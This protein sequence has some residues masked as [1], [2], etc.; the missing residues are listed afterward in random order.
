[1]PDLHTP[2]P[3]RVTGP[4]IRANTELG[5]GALVATVQ[6][7]RWQRTGSWHD[8][9]HT[10]GV[11]WTE[12]LAANARLIAA[13][14][15]MLAALRR[16]VCESTTDDYGDGETTIDAAVLLDAEQAIAKAEGEEVE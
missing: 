5:D 13:A 16:V 1:M 3:W 15:L 9:P 11:K 8:G 12:E 2:G 4:N 14:P 6:G 7:H 10:A